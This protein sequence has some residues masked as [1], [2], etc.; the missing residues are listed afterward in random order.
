[1]LIGDNVEGTSHPLIMRAQEK[2]IP[3]AELQV[4]LQQ[5]DAACK[6]FDYQKVRTILLK[7]VAE[8]EPQCGIEDF[9][10]QVQQA[11]KSNNSATEVATTANITN[12]TDITN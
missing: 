8:Y 4:L 6:A 1:M 9:L 2:E 12:V 7:T 11:S 5:L 3:W 10:W